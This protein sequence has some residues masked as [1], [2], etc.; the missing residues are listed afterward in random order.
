MDLLEFFFTFTIALFTSLLV[1]PFLRKWALD[2]GTVDMPEERK[3]H[4]KV[5]PRLGGIAI[6]LSFLLASIVF[7][8][9]N[10]MMRG[11]LAGGVIVFITGLVD[12]LVEL[13][14]KR[15][16]AGEIAACLTTIILGKLWLTNLGNLFGFGDIILPAW[17]GIPF[18]VFAV[19]GVINAINLIDGLDGLAGGLS[20]LSLSAFLIL[21]WLEGD[22]QTM[23]I[24]AGLIGSLLG[25]LKYNFYPARIFMGDAGSL[26][27]GFILGFLA[28][29]VTQQPQATTSPMVPIL[30]LALPLIDTIWVMG[31]RAISKTNPF[32]P[33]RT[34]LHHKFL[35]LGI[36]HRLTVLLIYF[37]SLFWICSALIMRK[38]PE[39]QLLLFLVITALL[40]YLTLKYLTKNKER[41]WFFSRDTGEGL[42]TSVHYLRIADTID[43]M[44]LGLM[45][46]IGIYYLLALC[47]AFT[48]CVVPWQIA[49]ILLISGL[50]FW[51]RPIR[52]NRQFCMLFVYGIVGLAAIE[53][54]HRQ[55]LQ[56]A[57]M[58][59]RRTGD[60]L[61]LVG[62]LISIF[63]IQFRRINE[64][65]LTSADYL[66]LTI[67]VFL[68][69]GLHELHVGLNLI[70]P[71]AR[72]L[73]AIV[74]LRTLTANNRGYQKWVTLM[75]FI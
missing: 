36:R 16:F 52:E 33:D 3:V 72:T 27:V 29:W 47:S 21:G 56:F 31:R 55:D 44:L 43:M 15:K 9:I 22:P 28:V 30:V 49:F 10:P 70:A 12:D 40:F 11:L 5:M 37:L 67:C 65:F 24:S 1:V 48:H 69:V 39:Y 71:L 73:V 64:F 45:A 25:F 17:I 68:I 63:K 51:F 41:Y 59:I 20:V 54:W 32:M 13:S 50:A 53:V 61:L 18:T 8:P 26:T 35:D 58:T 19:V 62:F 57:G 34:H 6:F 66:A 14:A 46:L 23:F 60:V 2:Q 74:I 7:I 38:H 42:R 4:Y 75:T